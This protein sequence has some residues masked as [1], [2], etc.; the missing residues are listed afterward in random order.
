VEDDLRGPQILG[1][2]SRFVLSGSGHIAGIVNPPAREQVRLRTNDELVE[3]PDEWLAAA[4]QHEGSWW[5]D[6]RKWIDAHL[7]RRVRRRAPAR[8]SSRS[9]RPRP[10]P[11]RAS[12]RMHERE[13]RSRARIASRAESRRNA[14][15][16][17]GA[18]DRFGRRCQA[19]ESN[20]AG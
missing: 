15:A 19:R 3:S 9:S 4:R 10:A 13:G 8:A 7:G 17:R 18:N 20:E 12:A 11:M 5:L 14:S 2:K 6:W 1:G 16:A